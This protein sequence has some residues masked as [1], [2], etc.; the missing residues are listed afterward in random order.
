MAEIAVIFPNRMVQFYHQCWT[1]SVD[2]FIKDKKI[3]LEDAI[4]SPSA[5]NRVAGSSGRKRR[6]V[7]GEYSEVWM[8][9]VW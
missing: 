5:F 9:N 3:N 1:C 4:L 2:D 8:A 6:T 7:V